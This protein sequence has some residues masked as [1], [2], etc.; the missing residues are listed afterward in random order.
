MKY[1]A[2]ILFLMIPVMAWSQDSTRFQIDDF[3][4]EHPHAIQ[5]SVRN[6]SLYS[7]LGTA[8][9]YVKFETPEIAHRTAFSIF[10]I[11]QTEEGEI[12]DKVILDDT[13]YQDTSYN[14][15]FTNTRHSFQ[16]YHQRLN[17]VPLRENLKLYQ[18]FG[19]VLDVLYTTQKANL[20]NRSSES[21][22]LY[23]SGGILYSIGIDWYFYQNFSLS[24][25]TMTGVNIGWQRRFSEQIETRDDGADQYIDGATLTGYFHE[26]SSKVL[27]GLSFHF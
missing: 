26:I 10:D 1:L 4:D 18:G 21:T 5:F 20:D 16:V 17:F 9:T 6:F 11:A 22:A 2:Q 19:P 15:G 24:A 27:L 3:I 23:I 25:E 7:S 12:L 13:T 14:T 8:L